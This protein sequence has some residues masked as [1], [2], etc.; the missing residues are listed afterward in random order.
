MARASTAAE[1]FATVRQVEVPT[2]AGPCALPILYRDAS[3]IG[4]FFRVDPAL[5]GACLPA[6]DLEPLVALGKAT[7]FLCAFEYRD[8]TVGVYNELGLA[9]L[10]KRAG[11]RPSLMRLALDLR[12][13]PE[14]ALWVASLPVTTPEACAAG[15]EIWGYPKYVTEITTD[16]GENTA[17]I[18]IPG[19]LRYVQ[20]S[21]RGLTTQGVPFV[22]FT[23]KDGVLIRTVIETSHPVRWSSGSSS[24]LDLTGSGQTADLCRALGLDGASPSLVFRGDALRAILPAGETQASK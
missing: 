14:Q 1:F 9:V 22:T 7:V 2:S 21:T 13:Q 6:G 11:S 3:L 19:E 4:A 15:K 23:R 17:A 24:R 16:F 20:P 12:A 8:T 18:E 10:A 5:A